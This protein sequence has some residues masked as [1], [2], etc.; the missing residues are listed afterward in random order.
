MTGDLNKYVD[1]IL[2]LQ[3]ENYELRSKLLELELE[4]EDQHYQQPQKRVRVPSKWRVI[5]GG[6]QG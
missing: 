5:V 6:V 1:M 2:N 4:N 3:K